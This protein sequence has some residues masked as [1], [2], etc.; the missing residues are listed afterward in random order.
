MISPYTNELPDVFLKGKKLIVKLPEKLKENTTYS[1]NFGEAIGD[2]TENNLA[3]NLTY[4][5]STGAFIDSLIISGKVVEATTG[6]AVKEAQVF[7][8]ESLAD[9]LIFKQQPDYLS[10]TDDNGFFQFKHLPQKTFQLAALSNSNNNL[11]YDSNNEQLAFYS[12]L[13]FPE[14]TLRYAHRLLLYQPI[15]PKQWQAEATKDTGLFKLFVNN[16]DSPTLKVIGDSTTLFHYTYNY[17]QDSILAFYST[18]KKTAQFAFFDAD[19]LLDTLR[20]Q[21]IELDTLSPSFK[22]TNW[23]ASKNQFRLLINKPFQ[24]ASTYPLELLDTNRFHILHD[25]IL[26]KEA[27]FSINT[28][29]PCLLEVEASWQE[30]STYQVTFQDSALTNI[31][32]QHNLAD[33]LSVQPILPTQIELS[34]NNADSLN[35][36]LAQLYEGKS[37]FITAQNLDSLKTIFTDIYPGAYTIKIIEDANQNGQW[38]NGIYGYVQPEQMFTTGEQPFQVKEGL[39]HSIDLTV[40]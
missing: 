13:V 10:K 12:D 8:Y 30:E 32:K 19:N 20:I 31:F 22:L 5:F 16:I 39:V 6:K 38:D 40:P 7:L 29:N 37:K 9:S 24:L 18:L 36:Y 2:I 26:F 17:A 34:L 35:T 15:I 1:F 25:S 27:S 14:D 3:E 4:V 23:G 33:T 28:I 21:Q 11:I